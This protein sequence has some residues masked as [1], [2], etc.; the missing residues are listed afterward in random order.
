M[1]EGEA[2]CVA[3]LKDVSVRADHD[4]IA[5]IKSWGVRKDRS[6]RLMRLD[7][8]QIAG[9]DFADHVADLNKV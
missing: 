6:K 8:T 2:G 1:G 9:T 5:E 3:A 7:D 4:T